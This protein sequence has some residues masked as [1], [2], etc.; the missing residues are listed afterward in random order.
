MALCGGLYLCSHV[1]E[2]LERT[3]RWVYLVSGRI[4]AKENLNPPMK[5]LKMIRYLSSSRET[6]TSGLLK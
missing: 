2:P 3:Y 1:S 5:K 6:R 4:L